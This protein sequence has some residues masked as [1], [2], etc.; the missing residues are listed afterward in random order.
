MLSKTTF[1]CFGETSYGA[2]PFVVLF[3]NEYCVLLVVVMLFELPYIL[4]LI[5]LNGLRSKLVG[6]L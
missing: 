5:S 6:T 2:P 4:L 3:K 1:S